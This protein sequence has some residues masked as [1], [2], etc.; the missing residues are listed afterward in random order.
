MTIINL[1][2][3]KKIRSTIR[4]IKPLDIFLMFILINLRVWSAKKYLNLNFKDINHRSIL[5]DYKYSILNTHRPITQIINLEL[6][7]KYLVKKK[8]KGDF[9]EAGV[10][11][12]G[13]SAYML[14]SFLRNEKFNSR[15][16]WGFDSF[17]GMP[18]PTKKD[19]IK[20]IN[21]V[22]ENNL[23]KK[24]ID[25]ELVG[26][27]MNRANY[28]QCL[29]Y[30]ID[31]NYPRSNIKLIKGWFQNTIIQNK[32]KINK[33]SLLRIDADFYES[34]Y[35]V[36]NNLYDKIVP[37]GVIIIDDY[38]SFE[39]CKKAVDDFF[40]K[41]KLNLSSLTMFDNQIGYFYK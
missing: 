1:K 17:E 27:P 33:I 21:W 8:I 12:G 11:T 2:I 4:F 10:F 29:K 34:T 13:S 14:L 25:G 28:S 30:L 37:G 15:T 20:A 36:L 31:T 3:Y 39:G 41:R 7:I 19:G 22:Y 23:K 32:T 5:K 24:L 38:G 6:I 18:A 26:N 35:F 16:F 40:H 9:V